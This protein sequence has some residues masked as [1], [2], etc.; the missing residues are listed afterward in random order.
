ME[1]LNGSRTEILGAMWYAGFGDVVEKPGMRIVDSAASLVGHRQH[2]F[3]SG[4]WKN[5]IPRPLTTL[6]AR[7]PPEIFLRANRSQIV[8]L[9]AIKT[10]TPWFSTCLKAILTGGEEVKFSRRQSQL[11]RERNK[12]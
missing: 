3:G 8:N 9:R 5:W 10:I 6:E 2:S 12:L 7:L 4:R 1:L 11:F